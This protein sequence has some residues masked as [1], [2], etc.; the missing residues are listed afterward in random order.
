VIRDAVTLARK[1]LLLEVRRREVVL[2][3]VQYVMSTLVIVHFAIAGAGTS[4]KAAAGMLWAAILF[5]AV[6]S[7]NRCFTADQEEGALDALQLA[8]IDRAA[9]WLGKVFAQVAFL[10]IMEAVAL[11]AFWL[12]FFGERGPDPVPVIAAVALANIGLAAVGVLVAG[13]AQATR[14]RDVLL[15]VLFLPLS[16]PLV[17]GAVTATLEAFPGGDSSARA[18]G[19]L[20]VF[21][22]LFTSLAWGTFEHL[23]GE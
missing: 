23:S 5:T 13:L 15:P 19:F 3:M 21:N 2:A 18:L 17:I 8:P 9:I 11:P 6:L 4:E 10:T 20:V 22:L 7:L 12:F 1:D 14:A 16:I